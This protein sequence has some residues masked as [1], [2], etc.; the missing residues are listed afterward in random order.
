MGDSTFPLLLYFLRELGS[1]H[2]LLRNDLPSDNEPRLHPRRFLPGGRT[3]QDPLHP[4]CGLGSTENDRSKA[5][6]GFGVTPPPSRRRPSR[7]YR[8]SSPHNRHPQGPSEPSLPPTTAAPGACERVST[9]R[10][11]YCM[12]LYKVIRN[13]YRPAGAVENLSWRRRVVYGARIHVR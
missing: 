6:G 2:L 8:V 9:I 3:K 12:R 11:M 10:G 1:P 7:A 13:R 4:H 5:F